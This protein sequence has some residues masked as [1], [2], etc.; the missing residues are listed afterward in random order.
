LL[1]NFTKIKGEAKM[2]PVLLAFLLALFTG[3]TIVVI[4]LGVN[5]WAPLFYGLVAG[6]VAG[7]INLGLQIG[8]ACALMAIGFYTYGGATM[9]DYS[10]GAIFGVFVGKSVISSGGT[11]ND[12]LAQAAIVA[13]AI[14]LF[15]TLFDILGRGTTTIFQHGGDRALAKRDLGSFQR[16]H[17]AG[18]I[19]WGLSRF[20]PVFVGMLFIDRY[21]V[22]ADFITRIAWLS[23]GLG[24]VGA[25]L[26][27]VGFALLLSYM[28]IAV[29]WPYMLLG[30]VLFAYLKM[31]IVGIAIIGIAAAGIY[32]KSK[33]DQLAKGEA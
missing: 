19:P 14:A 21:Q 30:Y 22:V 33:K 27:A 25:A 20:I 2:S 6:I 8:S 12:A 10:I 7:D 31:P 28:E 15:M 23:R 9:P 5:I 16:W 3:V 26:P 11:L 4:S 18:T 13:S 1:Y 17:L 24:V 32:M 29:Y